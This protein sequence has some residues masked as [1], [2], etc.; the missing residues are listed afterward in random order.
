DQTGNPLKGVKL[1]ASNS[2]VRKTTYSNDEGLFRFADLP[3]G[4]YEVRAAAPRL[5]TVIQSNVRVGASPAEVSLVMEVENSGVEE[6]K[7]ME[8]APLINT[9]SANLKETT[10]TQ[11]ISAAAPRSRSSEAHRTISLAPP[12]GRARRP[13]LDPGLP[14]ALAGGHDLSFVAV[15]PETLIS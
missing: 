8:K 6:V 4:S 12:E 1:T 13:R 10:D 15:A 11:F 7:V 14:A 2:N 5:R 9:A 3:P